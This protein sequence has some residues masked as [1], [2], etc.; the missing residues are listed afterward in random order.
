MLEVDWREYLTKERRRVCYFTGDSTLP[1]NEGGYVTSLV[2]V[3]YQ[4]TKEAVIC[5]QRS[6]RRLWALRNPV[7]VFYNDKL[8]GSDVEL[9]KILQRK[10][11]FSTPEM[12]SFFEHR[13]TT[14]Y[15][16][17][18]TKLGL[19]SDLLPDT[20][21]RFKDLCTGDKEGSYT[22]SYKHTQ[23]HRVCKL[24]W[25]QG[26]AAPEGLEE[27][28][29]FADESFCVSHNRRGVLSLANKGKN[30]NG[31]SFFITLKA[32]PW[33]DHHYVAFGQLVEGADILD[34]IENTETYYEQ[35]LRCITVT[36]C[37]TFTTYKLPSKRESGDGKK[38][39][40]SEH[41]LPE[42]M[43]DVV[44]PRDV[45]S[46]ELIEERYV[47]GLYSLD[48]PSDFEFTSFDETFPDVLEEVP[49]DSEEEKQMVTLRPLKATFQDIMELNGTDHEE[50]YSEMFLRQRLTNNIEDSKVHT[51]A[52]ETQTIQEPAEMTKSSGEVTK[53]LSGIADVIAEIIMK[54]LDDIEKKNLA[55]F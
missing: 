45:S 32:S 51:G 39:M 21:Q 40:T 17:Y 7:A 26:G 25:I 42:D 9:L 18:I 53:E 24:G 44:D 15:K 35:P 16:N 47:Q 52:D 4:E 55:Q 22:K 48:I 1:R 41:E 6:D 33:M 36:D 10:Y 20:C 28:E 50:K 43:R 5:L 12:D 13:I 31:T 14:D 19:Y 38:T 2:I 37:G 27:E 46:H 23:I 49:L 29:M 11:Y 8:I 34:A 30:T 3:P 54:I